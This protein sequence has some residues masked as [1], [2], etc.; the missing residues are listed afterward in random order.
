M[1]DAKNDSTRLEVKQALMRHSRRHM[2]A[3]MVPQVSAKEVVSWIPDGATLAILGA[4]GGLNEATTIIDALA[5]RAA[6]E[7]SPCGLT[8]VHSSGLG[9]RATRGMSPLAIAG[10]AKRVIGGHWGQS[11]TLAEMASR[12]EF[13]A[14]NFPQGVMSQLYRAAAAGH[15]GILTHVGLQ[16]FVDPRSRGGKLNEVTQED[17]IKLME[18]EGKEYLFYPTVPVDFAIVRATTADALGYLSMEDEIAFLDTLALAQATHNNGGIVVAQ[19]QRVVKARSLHPKSVKVP[20]FLVDAIVVEPEQP[21]LY[22]GTI[23]RSFSGDYQVETQEPEL[24]PLDIRKVVARRALLEIKPGDVGNVGVGISDGVGV[25]AQEE[26]IHEDFT[27]TVELGPIGGTSIQGIFLGAG[28]N[29]QAVLDMPAQFDFYD[30]GGLDVALLSFAEVDQAGNVNVHAFGGKLMGTGGFI[31][32]AQNTKKVIFS[33]TLTA[34]GLEVAVSPEA[35]RVKREGRFTKFVAEMPEVTFS[36]ALAR[37]EGHEV[38][39]ITE[40]A[41]FT[42]TDQ[43]VTLTEIAPG[44]DIERDVIA[45]M[46]FRPALGGEVKVMDQR[47]FT[48]GIMNIAAWWRNRD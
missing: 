24:L 40:R 13:E 38:I 33:G 28:V 16:T 31:N 3:Q 37:A 26:G 43:G 1:P 9:D 32:I 6:A 19:V 29:T 17:L 39:Y 48:D 2:R 14:Y 36:A 34:G 5:E 4:G 8:I 44:V 7:G 23:N 41:V 22:F 25:V 15:P 30:G 42:L 21:Q 18:I 12:N 10:L 27:L 11:P 35:I 20:G 47:L 46:G 45:H